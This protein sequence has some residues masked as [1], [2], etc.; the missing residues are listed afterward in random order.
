MKPSAAGVKVILQKKSGTSYV[1]K[2]SVT[3][4]SQKLPNGVTAVGYVFSVQ[5]TVAGTFGYRVQVASTTTLNAGYSPL[6][7][8]KAT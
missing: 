4:K 3:T 5:L 6:V 1:T 2:T 7:I 8:V